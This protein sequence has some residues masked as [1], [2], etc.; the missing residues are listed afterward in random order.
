MASSLHVCTLHVLPSTT[1]RYRSCEQLSK[2]NGKSIM[3]LMLYNTKFCTLRLEPRRTVANLRG[4]E[5]RSIGSRECRLMRRNDPEAH[6]DAV[7][8][9]LPISLPFGITI[10]GRGKSYTATRLTD[11]PIR[12]GRHTPTA[13]HLRSSGTN[14]YV[15]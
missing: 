1:T 9:H 12:G 5:D 6:E 4:I 11:S 2:R 7:V 8:L 3:S 15:R 14:M 10:F 13:Y